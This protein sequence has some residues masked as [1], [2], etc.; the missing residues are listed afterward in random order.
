MS[1]EILAAAKFKSN[2]DLIEKVAELRYLRKQDFTLD[3]TFGQGNWWKLWRPESL[4]THTRRTDGSDFRGLPYPDNHFTAIAYDPPYVCPGGI[5]TST[6]KGMHDNYGMNESDGDGDEEEEERLFR[7]PEELQQMIND[8]LTEMMRLVK[9][10][11]RRTMTDDRPNGIVLAKCQNYIWSGRLWLGAHH[12][13]AHALELG[14]W[15]E[16]IFTH[17]GN[18]RAQPART[19]KHAAC[20]GAGCGDCIDGRLPSVAAHARQNASLLYVLRAPRKK[21]GLLAA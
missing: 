8:G 7:T 4:I 5:K 11:T 1:D 18:V 14:F 13:L 6:L 20:K 19:H 17:V 12:T 16:D 15:V 9:P 21:P 3:P 10:S 2:A